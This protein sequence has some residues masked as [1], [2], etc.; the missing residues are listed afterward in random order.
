MV[1]IN[2]DDFGMNESCSTAIAEAFEKELVTDTTIMANGE[3]FES[4]V[5]LAEERG[6]ADKIGIHLNITEGKPLTDDIKNLPDF[7]TD[8]Q[9]NKQYDWGKE[10]SPSEYA[11]VYRELSA[12]VEKVI[13]AG[14]KITHADSH[15]YIHNAPFIAPIAERVCRE[16]GITK[17][18]L[19]RN[20]GDMPESDRLKADSYRDALRSRGFVTTDYFGRLSEA[21]NT[22]L[23]ESIELLVHPDFDKDGNLIDRHGVEGGYPVGGKIPKLNV[24]LGEYAA[25]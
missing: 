24:K 13:N 21:E 22:A 5:K 14:I 20:W 2:A 18:R 25:L 7:V 11:A 19:M 8:G 6:F 15:H 3:F 12:Q 1:M 10:L 17:L 23:P 9:F 16:H 4:A